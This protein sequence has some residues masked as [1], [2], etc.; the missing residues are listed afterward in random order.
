MR[1]AAALFAVLLAGIASSNTA[2]AAETVIP[3]DGDVPASGPDHFFVPFTVPAGTVEIEI[4]HDDLSA[5]NILDWGLDDPDGFRGWGGGNTEPAVVGIDAASRSYV[6]GPI[7]PGTWNV[8][9]GKAKIVDTPAKYHIEVVLRDAAT[10]A[11]QPE[12]APYTPAPALSSGPRWYAGDFHVHSRESGDAR[13]DLDEIATFAR[14]Q[15]LDFVEISDHNVV[16]AQDFF[17]DAQARHP[18]LLLVP[19]MEWTTYQ[20]HAN[21]IG[22]TKWVDHKL[23]QPGVTVES[24]AAAVHAQGGLFS[25]NHPK[26]ALS[27]CIGCGWS[28]TL[29]ADQVDAM[30]IEN[31]GLTP[32]GQIFID[33]VLKLWDSMS[34]GGHHI[35]AL[36]G[37]D[38]HQAGQNEGA[39]GSPIANPTT[40]V[41]ADELSATAI[42]D[43]VKHGRTVVKLQSP[44]DPMIELAPSVAPDPADDVIRAASVELTVTVTGGTG[45]QLRLVH[46]GAPLDPV[47]VTSDPFEYKTTL[48]A[49]PAQERWRAEVLIGGKRHT[50][51]SHLW[52]ANA[53][54]D[55]GAGA[56]GSAG[57]AGTDAGSAGAPGGA[58]GSPGASSD[59]GG[60]GCRFGAEPRS[61]SA[62]LVL[63]AVG[64]GLSR[65]RRGR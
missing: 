60:C 20:G 7:K 14:A 40:M 25:I 11:A 41:Y 31:G 35:T 53:I 62:W 56:A 32:V 59:S 30:E 2:R 10:L 8:V 6:P 38:N 65:R 36:G 34:D 22:I 3:I 49:G 17:H 47:D 63:L 50:V 23:G 9:V 61:A 57:S 5:N 15:R 29:P 46:D 54:G 45:D 19:G 28:L 24:A 37:S 64:L 39:T 48:D 12:R 26:L 18:D 52:I 4:R 1:R 42:V 55:G 21:G 33:A 43:A 51:T 27:F 58:G 16:T 44:D 13:P